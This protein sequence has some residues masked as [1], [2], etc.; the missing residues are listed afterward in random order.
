MQN[1]VDIKRNLNKIR[2]KCAKCVIQSKACI[3]C[4]YYLTSC[5]RI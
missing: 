1:Q 3:V 2:A 4:Y 5:D